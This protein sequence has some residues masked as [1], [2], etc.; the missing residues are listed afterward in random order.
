MATSIY[1]TKN[2]Y[3]FDGTEIEIMPLK[4]KYLREFMDAFNKIKHAKNDDESMIVL[5]ECT[6]IAMKQ[7]FPEISKSIEDL[8]DNIDLPTVHVILDV[9]A[10]IKID[11]TEEN[12]ESQESQD[13]KSKAQKGDVGPSWEEFDLA[14]IESEVFLLGIW[15]DYNELEESLSLAEIMAIL[16]S[17]RE[18]DYQEKKFFASIQGVDLESD[19]NEERGQKEWENLKARVFSR[20]ATSDSNDVLSLQGQNARSVGFG[21]GMGLDYEDARDPNL[22]K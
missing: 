5:T 8:E 17:K 18:L 12:Q 22:I 6:R 20:G 9:A 1:K 10:N 14:K 11:Q 19:G 13:I 16:S 21:I 7:Y 2:I 3:L 15:K 4:I